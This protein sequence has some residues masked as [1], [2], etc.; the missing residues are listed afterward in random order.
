[1][2]GAG[3]GAELFRDRVSLFLKVRLL[4]KAQDMNA[5]RWDRP[6]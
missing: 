2:D 4:E 1:M 6:S 5:W 3:E